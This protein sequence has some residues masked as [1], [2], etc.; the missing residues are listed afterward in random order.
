MVGEVEVG[1]SGEDEHDSA[2]VVLTPVVTVG[3]LATDFGHNTW[4]HMSTDDR[5][6]RP[7]ASAAL[8]NEDDLRPNNDFR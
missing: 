4:P 8:I 2:D 6:P 1:L 5:R 3:L 7:E